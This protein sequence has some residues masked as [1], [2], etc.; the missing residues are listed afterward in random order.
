MRASR[1]SYVAFPLSGKAIV[2]PTS[3]N[4]MNP[5]TACPRP[6]VS[7]TLKGSCLSI[8]SFRS[9]WTTASRAR[10]LLCRGPLSLA[11]RRSRISSRVCAWF[12]FCFS[13]CSG[14]GREQP[15]TPREVK[16]TR[17]RIQARGNFIFFPLTQAVRLLARFDP[18]NDLAQQPR[19]AGSYEVQNRYMRRGSAAADGS[20]G[21]ATRAGKTRPILAA[22]TSDRAG[23]APVADAEP[24]DAH[25]LRDFEEEFPLSQLDQAGPTEV[26]VPVDS[27]LAG[28]DIL[29]ANQQVRLAV[30]VPVGHGEALHTVLGREV[31][32]PGH[33]DRSALR[34]RPEGDHDAF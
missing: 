19:R 4:C 5:L 17:R 18:P 2:F 20:A 32:L 16:Q 25:G 13:S 30:P 3:V 34:E 26:L 10:A 8:N 21:M 15:S 23:A 12:S 27:R 24:P 28:L 14:G 1:P 31:E 6:I 7:L 9:S 29:L 22:S 33:S 11:G